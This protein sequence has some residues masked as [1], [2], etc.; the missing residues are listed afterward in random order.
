[1]STKDKHTQ[2]GIEMKK[3][4]EEFTTW[5]ISNWPDKDAPL[6]STNFDAG[7]KEVAALADK[8]FDI[9]KRNAAMPEPS[10]NGPQYVNVTPAPWP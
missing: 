10:E 4:F 3:R 8:D 2:F 5:A 7:R 9:G 1:M 6:S